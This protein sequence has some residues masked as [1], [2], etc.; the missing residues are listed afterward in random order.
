M[1]VMAL[2][3]SVWVDTGAPSV[4]THFYGALAIMPTRLLCVNNW[5][6]PQQVVHICISNSQVSWIPHTKSCWE[7]FIKLDLILIMHSNITSIFTLLHSS[8]TEARALPQSL[9]AGEG[10]IF[11]EEV[12]CLEDDQG[13]LECHNHGVLGYHL[14][15]LAAQFGLIGDPHEGDVSISCEGKRRPESVCVC[16]YLRSYLTLLVYATVNNCTVWRLSRKAIWHKIL[17][18]PAL[19]VICALL[20]CIPAKL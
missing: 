17:A 14:C 6:F 13:L 15:G 3:N 7:W 10:P 2:W 19:L 16:V 4:T 18:F 12:N 8:I 1:R 11:L 20:N 9:F 5:D